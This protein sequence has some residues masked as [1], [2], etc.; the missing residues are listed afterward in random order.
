M[1]E[2]N[3]KQAD[4][5]TFLFGAA[6]LLMMSFILA[7]LSRLPFFILGWFIGASMVSSFKRRA[8][9]AKKVK[10][11]LGAGFISYSLLYACFGVQWL[12]KSDFSGAL[13]NFYW[14]QSCLYGL[15]KVWDLSIPAFTRKW[16]FVTGKMITTENISRFVFTSVI[17]GTFAALVVPPIFRLIKPK[18]ETYSYQPSNR[19]H[20]LKRMLELPYYVFYHLIEVPIS[21][22]VAVGHSLAVDLRRLRAPNFLNFT[23]ITILVA[24]VPFCLI[25][26]AGLFELYPAFHIQST[27]T[28]FL[29]TVL[30]YAPSSAYFIGAGIGLIPFL[31]DTFLFHAFSSRPNDAKILGLKKKSSTGFSLGASGQNQPFFLTENNLAYHVEIVAPTGS[32]KTNILKNLIEDRISKGHGVIF[33]DYKADFEVLTWMHKLAKVNKRTDDLRLISLTN[34]EFS[35]PYNPLEGGTSSE[36]TSRLMNSFEWSTEQYYLNASKSALA[37][38][39]RGF[40]EYRDLTK[41]NFHVGHIHRALTDSNYLRMI[42]TELKENNKL[43]WDNLLEV[44]DKLDKPSDAKEIRGLISNLES[45]MFSSV[46]PLLTTDTESSSYSLKEAVGRGRITYLLMNSLLLKE[47]SRALGKL[48]LQDL[49]S[50]VGQRFA[51]IERGENHHKPLTLI[52]DEFAAF[53]IPEFIDFLDRARSAG[54]GV[55]IAHQDRADLKSISEEFQSRVEA[56]TNTTI[57]SGVKDPNDAEHFAGMIG[58]KT[59]VKE[60]WQE[61]SGFF[62]DS[63]TGVKS[64]RTVDEY[65]IHP[66]V[67]KQLKQG[68]VLAVSRTVDPHFGVVRIPRAQ[69]FEGVAVSKEELVSYFKKSRESY[70]KENS[71]NAFS[72]VATSNKP[73]LKLQVKKSETE[74]VKL[75]DETWS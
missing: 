38:V 59:A 40:V 23:F 31:G 74:P 61:S 36:L 27:E 1:S 44:A 22:C 37:R 28:R 41:D 17:A 14:Y 72:N 16:L 43:Y 11:F 13:T 62:G 39:M 66:N 57:V 48:F 18:K 4:D 20:V 46:G 63:P 34:P 49:M 9:S 5:D 8:D 64:K 30:V 55:I 50:F 29:L 75:N 54:I 67:I 52:I 19:F 51:T 32:G 68:E 42:A 25:K 12:I 3:K 47:S 24:G 58:T 53:A 10:A 45:L 65:I 71:E 2:Q 35:V 60:T 69:E 21:M 33:L 7:A 73:G 15:V 6:A 70:M 56:N 26:I